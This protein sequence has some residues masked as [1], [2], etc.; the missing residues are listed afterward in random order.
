MDIEGLGYKTVDL[1]LTEGLIGDPADVYVLEPDDLLG[2]EG[3]GEVSVTNLLG[4]IA[5]SKDRDVGRLLTG[6]GI[7]HVGGTV[8]K[9]LA[10]RFGSIDALASASAEDIETISGVGPEIAGSV[11]DWFADEENRRLIDKFRVAGVRMADPV[12]EGD[13][14]DLLTG[15]T[16]VI[17]GSLE[18]LSRSEAKAAVENLGGKVTG[19]VSRKTTAV[20]AGASPGSKLAKATE[21]D[22]PILD[23]AAFGRLLPGIQGLRGGPPRLRRPAD[24][25]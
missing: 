16:V 8:A 18:G 4:A 17:T 10:R 6:L 9:V 23:E 22:V 20:I 11:V 25:F 12:L 1:L 21:L 2:R 24:C 19:S 15:V 3:W 13:R 7:D 14:S 5:D